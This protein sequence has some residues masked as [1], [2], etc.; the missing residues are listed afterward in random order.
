MTDTQ[1]PGRPSDAD[2][3]AYLDGELPSELREWIASQLAAD[4]GLS[5]R[6]ALLANGARQFREAFEPLLSR[7]PA[8]KLACM[9]AGL[10]AYRHGAAEPRAG[11]RRRP[12]LALLAACAA[13]LLIGAGADRLLP[14][15]GD[16]MVT[17]E[18]DET[19]EWRQA[20]AS[21]VTFYTPETLASIADDSVARQRELANLSAKLGVPL[22]GDGSAIPGLALKWTW[23]LQYD[24]RPLAELVY[25]DPRGGPVALCI[26]A[27][28]EA[29]AAPRQ[30]QREGLNVIYWS[31]K[32][33]SFMLA[34]RMTQ[35]ELQPLADDIYRRLST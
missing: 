30:E 21:Y 28:G 4:Q 26:L 19:E 3:V 16:M 23:L 22:S 12:S 8:S 1:S 17:Q 27:D 14:A 2:L 35:A 10:S 13:A 15:I 11:A 6:L 34:G 33:R 18:E 9:L 20:V 7:A 24:G 5:A 31:A 32:G 25:V 29:D